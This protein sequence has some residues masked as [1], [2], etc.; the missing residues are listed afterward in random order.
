MSIPLRDY[1]K[2]ALEAIEETRQRGVRR[3]L[4]AHATGLGKTV[5]AAHLM[6]SWQPGRSLFVVHR[7]ELIRQTVDKLAMVDPDLPV[8][9]VQ[10]PRNEVDAPVVV[11][12]VATLTRPGRLEQLRDDFAL[13]V[14]DEAHH[15]TAPSYQHVFKHVT[16]T[17]LILG[18]TATPQRGDRR[19]LSCFDEI[20][21]SMSIV[22]G[23]EAGYLADLR[24]HIAGTD[25][26]L[27]SVT[28]RGGDFTEGSLGQEMSR[29][30]AIGQ[31]VDA[32]Q[33]HAS[34]RTTLAFTPTV[35]TA[36]TLAGSFCQRG[37][38]AEAF[39]G[40]TPIKHRRA[41][42]ERF[43]RGQTQVLVNCAVLTEGFDEPAVDCILLARPTKSPLL[44]QQI[45]G[46]AARPYPGKSEALVLDVTGVS[47]DHD[48][49]SLPSLA[50]MEPSEV[51]PGQS[52][53]EA[54]EKSASPAVAQRRIKRA[55]RTRAVDL[56]SR[57]SLNWIHY[58]RSLLL[59]A[60][61]H[62][63]LMIPRDEDGQHW[64]VG[65]DTKGTGLS[66]LGTNLPVGYATGIAED[67]ARACGSL[68]RSNGRWRR[69]GMTDGQRKI[70]RRAG[71]DD[72][73][74]AAVRNRGHASDLITIISARPALAKLHAANRE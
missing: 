26:N 11:A 35:D 71:L 42:L 72:S 43:H 2:Q 64:A 36:H 32:W 19:A 17:N 10:G 13:C 73:K 56:L 41:V 62:V 57:G 55:Q 74:L 61:E 58:D 63:V 27:E 33:A 3:Q 51:E 52:L 46:R 6:H 45:V 70:L 28:V 24:G 23:I 53:A 67:Y 14:I 7:D 16:K 34:D 65:V 38:S 30:G 31:I 4:V 15:A 59:P 21:H 66:V 9:V 22:D 69:H 12:S 8:G 39:D 18:L 20:A 48:L 44:Y 47:G 54:S 50:G 37:V 49:I 60:G 5:L 25:M 29:S 1:Q 40:S 68:A